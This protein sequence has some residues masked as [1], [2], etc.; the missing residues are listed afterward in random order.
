MIAMIGINVSGR[1][2]P[3]AARTE[4]TAHSASSSFRPNPSIPFVNSSAPIR[5]TT[6]APARTRTSTSAL[7]DGRERHAQR[8]HEEDQP[9]HHRHEPFAATGISDEGCEDAGCRGGDHGD[10]PEPQE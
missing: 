3:T 9:G 7:E 2:V 5:M 4:P 10:E 8:N 6:N 1:A